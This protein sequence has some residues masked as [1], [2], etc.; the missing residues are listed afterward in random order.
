MALEQE[1]KLTDSKDGFGFGYSVAISGNTAIIGATGDD[2]LQ[3]RQWQRMGVSGV[4]AVT[5][6]VFA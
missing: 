1:P 6:L 3:H 5:N 2:Q 4:N